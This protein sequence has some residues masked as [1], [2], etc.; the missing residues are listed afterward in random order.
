MATPALRALNQHYP[1]ARITVVTDRWTRPAIET[2]PRVEQIVDWPDRSGPGAGVRLGYGLRAHR[3][4]IGVALDRS[5]VAALALRAAGIPVRA[6]ID[7]ASRGIGLTHRVHPVPDQHETA[8][9]LSV[10][11][12]LGVEDPVEAPEYHVPDQTLAD[13]SEM[14]PS[15]GAGPVV[16]VHP[17]GAVNPGTQMLEKRWPATSFGELAALLVR[18]AGATIVLVGSGTDRS[19]VDTV[20]DFARVPVID[21]CGQLSLPQL[22]A[23]AKRASLYVGNDSGTSHLASAVGTPVVTIFGPTSP[24]RYRPLGHRSV[25]CAPDASWSIAG[26]IDLRYS[27]RE[28]L[29]NIASVPVPQVL[30]ACLE[31][32]GGSR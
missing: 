8:L 28:N 26:D 27:G 1:N 31:L 15:E 16:V 4:D 13:A 21:L 9:Y 11:G 24:K 20:R 12:G 14:V 18:E 22:A 2:N 7:S 17:G 19:A 29:P 3:F 32:L 5:P 6:G 25:V 23:V 30:N 10:I